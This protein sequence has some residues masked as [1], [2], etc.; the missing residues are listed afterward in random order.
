MLSGNICRHLV[1]FIAHLVFQSFARIEYSRPVHAV[2]ASSTKY[3]TAN[4]RTF[5][6]PIE[7]K[8]SKSNRGGNCCLYKSVHFVTVFWSRSTF[9]L[10]I[11]FA[12][13]QGNIQYS[14]KPNIY[15]CVQ[16]SVLLFN[17]VL[18]LIKVIINPKI[19]LNQIFDI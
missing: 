10:A 14:I 4:H 15:K 3:I 8:S 11:S 17:P 18:Y 1:Y 5:S 6:I 9:D 12:S 2:W 7:L 16:L 13:Q 19:Q